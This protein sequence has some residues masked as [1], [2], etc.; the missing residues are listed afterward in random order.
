MLKAHLDRLWSLN[1][2]QEC[3]VL[4]KIKICVLSKQNILVQ[5]WGMCKPA[6]KASQKLGEGCKPVSKTDPRSALSSD[7]TLTI[8]DYSNLRI[9]VYS[10]V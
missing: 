5:Y 8:A 1:I 6:F 9:K 7:Y 4:I 10:Q 3:F 2:E